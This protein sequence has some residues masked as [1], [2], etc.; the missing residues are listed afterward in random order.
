MKKDLDYYGWSIVIGWCVFLGI[1][2]IVKFILL[3]TA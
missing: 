1:Y 2:I 3:I